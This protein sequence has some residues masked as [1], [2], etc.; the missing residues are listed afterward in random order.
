[1]RGGGGGGGGAVMPDQPKVASY[2]PV[3]VVAYGEVVN[4]RANKFQDLQYASS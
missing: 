4:S 1:M 3:R 2:A